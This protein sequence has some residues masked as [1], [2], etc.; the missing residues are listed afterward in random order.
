[1]RWG[2]GPRR[3]R[4]LLLL[5]RRFLGPLLRFI[6]GERRDERGAVCCRWSGWWFVGEGGEEAGVSKRRGVRMRIGI[7]DV[8]VVID[9]SGRLKR[10]T[11]NN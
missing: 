2:R 4:W 10:S 6:S 7:E 3:G 1:M 9:D 5:L 8:R 11:E